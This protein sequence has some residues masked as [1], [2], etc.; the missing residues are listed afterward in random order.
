MSSRLRSGVVWRA[1]RTCTIQLL[2]KSV[3]TGV[4]AA[5]VYYNPMYYLVGDSGV[6]QAVISNLF[7]KPRIPGIGTRPAALDVMDAEVVQLE[8]DTDLVFHGERE[9]FGLST[10]SKRGIVNLDVLH[11]GNLRV[12][13]PREAGSLSTS[14]ENRDHFSSWIPILSRGSRSS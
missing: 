10:V 5:V 2:P 14:P 4:R 3:A 12:I 8:R 13:F 7:E 9:V 6:L 1:S 11:Q